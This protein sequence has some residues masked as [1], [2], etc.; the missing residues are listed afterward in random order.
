MHSHGH[1]QCHTS[2]AG[3]SERDQ[4]RQGFSSPRKP[5]QQAEHATGQEAAPQARPTTPWACPTEYL[6][7][8]PRPRTHQAARGQASRSHHACWRATCCTL[9]RSFCGSGGSRQGK[10]WVRVSQ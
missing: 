5:T 4:S 1:G 6:T 7:H 9:P 8:Q 10:R 3:G 2:K